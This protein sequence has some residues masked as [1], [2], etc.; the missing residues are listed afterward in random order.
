MGSKYYKELPVIDIDMVE[1]ISL[2]KAEVEEILHDAVDDLVDDNRILETENGKG[3]YEVVKEL[4]VIK[5]QSSE[6]KETPADV[7]NRKQL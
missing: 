5:E 1:S 2:N 4:E 7:E 3:L 6:I